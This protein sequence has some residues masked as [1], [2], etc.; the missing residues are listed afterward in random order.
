[1]ECSLQVD[2][3]FHGFDGPLVVQRFPHQPELADTV[4]RA[5]KEL[6]YRLG[7]LNG[8]N[9]TGFNVAQMMVADGLRGSTARLFLRPAA[10]KQ[11]L[12][13]AINARVTKVLVD[14]DTRV[15][16]GVQFL[17]SAGVLK[18]ALAAREVILS[19]GAIG[20]AQILLLSGVGPREDLQ[21]LG[22]PVLADLP[23]GRN[24][25]N[26]ISVGVGFYMNDTAHQML[27]SS[28]LE[29]FLQSRKGPMTSTGLTQ[30]TGFLKSK[31]VTDG[32]PDLQVF[33]DGYSARCSRS[34]MQNECASGDVSQNAACGQRYIHSRPT[35]VR[36]RSKG[37]LRLRSA[38]PLDPP[39][40]DP[41]YLSDPRD[42]DVLLEGIRAVVAMSRTASM[43]ARGFRLDDRPKAGC[44]AYAFGSEAY[45][46]CVV[47]RH[48][49]PENHQAGTCAMGP[50]A[51]LDARLRVRGLR[52]LRVADASIFPDNPN[53]NPV[54]AIIMVAE[55]A[56]DM[57]KQDWKPKFVPW[58]KLISSNFR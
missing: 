51:V 57:I 35:N 22:I 17:D 10:R 43:R 44:E 3:G 26:H 13:V 40:M 42:L 23:V 9:Q 7:D 58:H 32:V 36:V 27:T 31:F 50:D 29:T 41:R 45:W 39:L 33:F 11:N 49:G 20:S 8:A 48:T 5:A 16:T 14:P 38:D 6:G 4:L 24:L 28:A 56:A 53:S 12:R 47:Q 18:T 52:Q 15:A 21:T 55:K 1:M 34:G 2:E 46:R 25:H 19:A 54:A 30:T 37:V